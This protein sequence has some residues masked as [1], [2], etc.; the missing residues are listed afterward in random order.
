[1][2]AIV[3]FANA[4]SMTDDKTGQDREGVT[5]EY[6][7][8]ENLDPVI[9]E[10]GSKGYKHVKESIPLSKL[11]KVQAIPGVYEFEYG[12][13]VQKG[14]PVMKLRDI[15]FVCTLDGETPVKAGA[16]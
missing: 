2:R 1:M 16:K 12:Y 3:V 4:W 14:K 10:D 5:L 15:Q 9:N 7:M 13:V 8:A 6:L 11:P